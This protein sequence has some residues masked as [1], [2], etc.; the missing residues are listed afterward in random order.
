MPLTKD[1]VEVATSDSAAARPGAPAAKPNAAGGAPQVRADAVST[2][3]PVRVYGSRIINVPGQLEP[4]TE[5]FEEQTSTMIVFPQGAVLRMSTTVAVGQ[6]LV[7]TNTGTK[8]DA[9][10]RVVKVR[11]FSNTQGYVEVEFTTAQPGYWGAVRFP[12]D[13]PAPA[14][15]PAAPQASVAPAPQQAKPT[16]APPQPKPVAVAPPAPAAKVPAAPQAPAP[17][18]APP[19]PVAAKPTAPV[20]PVAPAPVAPAPV[21]KAP[22]A[23]V[24]VA[25]PAPVAAAHVAPAPVAKVEA[26]APVAALHAPQTAELDDD[27]VETLLNRIAPTVAS[28]PAPTP[29]PVA[30]APVAPVEIPSAPPAV[31]V[32][33]LSLSDLRGD[34]IVE[35]PLPGDDTES[36]DSSALGNIAAAESAVEAPRR[37]FGS[38]SGGGTFAAASAS[39]DEAIAESA[40]A[41]TESSAALGGD[42]AEPQKKSN[43]L[44]IAAC[45]GALAVVVAGGI[46]Y[47]R[48]SV[49]GSKA[50]APSS[51]FANDSKS[52]DAEPVNQ[53][54]ERTGLNNSAAPATSTPS[55]ANSSAP[56]NSAPATPVV[57]SPSA[58]SH[59]VPPSNTNSGIQVS[60]GRSAAKAKALAS[61]VDATTNAHPVAAQRT[62]AAGPGAAPTLDAPGVASSGNAL[63]GL[64]SGND[65]S[66]LKVPELKV[67]GPVHVGGQ[68]K[69]P[70]VISH[71]APVYPLAAKEAGIY[72]DV[73]L[74]TTIDQKG[75]VVNAKIISGPVMLRQPA[76]DALKRW[77]YAP[78]TLNGQPISVAMSVTIKFSKN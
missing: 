9:I 60:E 15:A 12:S 20:A 36:I 5:P 19:A 34:A 67:E 28:A 61:V 18:A 27:D 69:E 37:T 25:P 54:S 45:I 77:R 10:C 42:Y 70:Q 3:V 22:A 4:N 68:V 8:A 16:A 48:T 51:Q 40:A 38:F 31:T 78:S 71:V 44:M 66:S 46:F 47:F 11:T 30:A 24:A 52:A 64:V 2:E 58:A 23:P 62:D 6:M 32:P 39:T 50:A 35:A 1:S 49:A 14:S 75:N 29:A 26:P 21:A 59:E 57:V 56:A 55:S 43:F 74:Q 7:V 63:S 72:G 65:G 73:V 13:G 53:P 33:S 76:L 41:H 17:V